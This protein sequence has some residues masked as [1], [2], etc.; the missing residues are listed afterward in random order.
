MNLDRYQVK[1]FGTKS[2]QRSRIDSSTQ[3]LHKHE[4]EIDERKELEGKNSR[5]H[6]LATP[7]GS[8]ASR[9]VYVFYM[10]WRIFHIWPKFCRFFRSFRTLNKTGNNFFSNI[11]CLEDSILDCQT[12]F[13]FWTKI[14][15]PYAT[16][17]PSQI[18]FRI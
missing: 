2:K 13:L 4:Y 15:F 7:R 8:W 5:T 11:K 16:I 3:R 18:G 6:L 14:K 1:G 9:C 10:G 12:P 17:I